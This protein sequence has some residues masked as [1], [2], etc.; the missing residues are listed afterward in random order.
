M[1]DLDTFPLSTKLRSTH[2]YKSNSK[3]WK[4]NKKKYSINSNLSWKA[5]LHL[6]SIVWITQVDRLNSLT[7]RNLFDLIASACQHF[8]LTQSRLRPTHCV[9]SAPARRSFIERILWL[10][11]RSHVFRTLEN[12]LLRMKGKEGRFD[13]GRCG[14][15]SEVRKCSAIH[16]MLCVYK[17]ILFRGNVWLRGKIE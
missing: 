3:R 7:T 4:K 2:V 14:P 13:W 17:E 5:G 16:W 12:G 9:C 8:E 15:F 6:R 11:K 1:M 10:R